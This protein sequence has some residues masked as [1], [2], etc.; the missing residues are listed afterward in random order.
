MGFRFFR[1]KKILPGVTL[2][3]SKSGPSVSLG[4]KGAK[5]TIGPRGTRTTVGMP[6]TGMFYTTEH[7]TKKGSQEHHDLSS[8]GEELDRLSPLS[9]AT[10]AK[11]ADLS[12]SLERHDLVNAQ[13]V[14]STMM[15]ESEDVLVKLG[16]LHVP[17]HAARMHENLTKGMLARVEGLSLMQEALQQAIDCPDQSN[18][19]LLQRGL[20][21]YRESASYFEQ[22]HQAGLN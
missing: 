20:S 9:F 7:R 22:A 13:H 3:F 2:N 4:P 10:D 21:R 18:G 1:R 11:L 6:G 5:F 14:V 8:Y 19:A 16:R 12:A 17:P 15:S